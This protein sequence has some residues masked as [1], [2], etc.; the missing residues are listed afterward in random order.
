M[1]GKAQ[2]VGVIKVGTGV[3]AAFDD[4]LLLGIQFPSQFLSDN[5]K[6]SFLNISG[7]HIFKLYCH[8]QIPSSIIS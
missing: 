2:V 8:N 4:Q 7:K 3:N 6:T 1:L 5:F